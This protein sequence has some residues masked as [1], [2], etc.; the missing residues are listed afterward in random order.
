MKGYQENFSAM[1]PD[2]YYDPGSRARKAEKILRVLCDHLGA[3]LGDRNVLD[4]G[5][6]TGMMSR[7]LAA[8]FGQVIGVDIDVEAIEHAKIHNAESNVIFRVGD[9][10][11]TGLDE[12]S[13]DVVV[14]SHVYEHVPDPQRMLDEIERVLRPGGVCY[15]AAENRLVFR[16]GDYG[17]PFL[18][19]VPK[20][21]GHRYLRL[22]GRGDHYYETLLTVWQLRRLTRRFDTIDYTRRVLADPVAFA[23]SDLVPPKSLKQRVALLLTDNAYWLFPNYLWLLRKRTSSSR[24]H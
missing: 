24:R 9:A 5:C 8:H 13:V 4:I 14:C 23:A 11:A 18:S 10:M 15:F 21:I 3:D 19:W 22:A 2:I 1:H 17:L 7:F 20:W 6:S 12:N 16:E